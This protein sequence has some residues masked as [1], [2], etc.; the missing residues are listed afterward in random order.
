MRILL[1]HT[2]SVLH[3]SSR[4]LLRDLTLGLQT[5]NLVPLDISLETI[6]L[7]LSANPAS[8]LEQVCSHRL[9][10]VADKT[11]VLV[12]HGPACHAIQHPN[13][14]LFFTKEPNLLSEWYEHLAIRTDIASTT[15]S[16]AHQLSLY[17]DILQQRLSHADHKFIGEAK[18]ICAIDKGDQ[19]PA[20]YGIPFESANNAAEA[21]RIVLDYI[22]SLAVK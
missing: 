6:T 11:D 12:T 21:V 14:F 4:E 3:K 5:A 17:Q 2:S 9:L 13:K 1:A 20:R 10:E 8:I 19:M 18:G 22:S 15:N 7:P 16:T